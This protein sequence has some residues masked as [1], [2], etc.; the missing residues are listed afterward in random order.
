MNFKFLSS[1]SVRLRCRYVLAYVSIQ[2]ANPFKPYFMLVGFVVFYNLSIIYHLFVYISAKLFL[3]I[4]ILKQSKLIYYIISKLCICTL[5]YPRTFFC[6]N[7]FIVILTLFCVI[8]CRVSPM[9]LILV[10]FF[11][12]SFFTFYVFLK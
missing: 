10:V 9:L 12:F 8:V 7:L 6:I 2:Y 1:L 3:Y 11:A 5:S 4:P